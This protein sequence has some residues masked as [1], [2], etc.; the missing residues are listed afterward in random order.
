M[1]ATATREDVALSVREELEKEEQRRSEEKARKE[2]EEEQRRLQEEEE[3]RLRKEEEERKQKEE[4]EKKALEGEE[5]EGVTPAVET[6]E[7]TDV[8]AAVQP[9]APALNREIS[10]Y[11]KKRWA[12]VSAHFA[13]TVSRGFRGARVEERIALDHFAKYV[14]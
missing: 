8:A 6:A 10:D 14:I 7:P 3:E 2:E 4:E 12:A 1:N 9:I 5:E 13:K 11:L